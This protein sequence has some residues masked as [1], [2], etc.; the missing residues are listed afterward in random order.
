MK[1]IILTI[2]KCL[3]VNKNDKLLPCTQ[4]IVSIQCENKN[5]VFYM[6]RYDKE[7][8]KRIFDKILNCNV[9]FS[10]DPSIHNEVVDNLYSLLEKTKSGNGIII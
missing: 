3:Q 9:R 7:S 10:I 8:Y 1:N 6:D 4:F 5:E 2:E